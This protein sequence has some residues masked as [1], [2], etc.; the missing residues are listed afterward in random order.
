M[1]RQ[2]GPPILPKRVWPWLLVPLGALTAGW[3][4]A[5]ELG[6]AWVAGVVT[7]GLLGVVGL[8]WWGTETKQ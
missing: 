1:R 6:E 3:G 5:V 4:A 2:E 8:V 7:A